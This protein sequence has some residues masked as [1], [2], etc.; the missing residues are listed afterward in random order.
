MNF[1]DKVCKLDPNAKDGKAKD[2]KDGKGKDGKEKDG[3]EKDDK[4]KDGK[5][6]GV[7]TEPTLT[8]KHTVYLRSQGTQTV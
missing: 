5:D 7:E 3:K 8:A 6:D 1:K 2:D 4:E